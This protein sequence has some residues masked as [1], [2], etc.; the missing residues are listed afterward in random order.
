M[1]N[2]K[3]NELLA[4]HLGRNATDAHDFNSGRK[5][6]ELTDQIIIISWIIHRSDAIV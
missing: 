4:L 2:I 6:V 5:M 1:L 3:V